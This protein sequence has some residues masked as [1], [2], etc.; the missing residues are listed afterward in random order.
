MNS[1]YSQAASL[2][3]AN[4]PFVWASIISQDGSTPRSAGAQMIIRED[5]I[6]A[7][8]GGG[9]ME[10]GVIKAARESV[11]KDRRPMILDYDLS[12]SE[13]A[14]SDFICGG[15]CRILLAYMEPGF[16]PVFEAAAEAESRGI[17]AWLYYILD[18]RENAIK[19]FSLAINVNS[20]RLVG[21][22]EGAPGLSRD[23][24]L[25]PVRASIHGDSAEG[26][27]CFAD[28]VGS[29]PKLYLLGGGHVSQ[30]V[31]KLAV[32][33][34]FSVTVVDDRAEYASA[35]RFPDCRCIVVEDFARLPDLP[36]DENS[37][38]IIMT[39]GHAYDRDALRWALGKN[40]RY[41]GMI[42]SRSKRDATYKA[43]EKEG[44]PM[45]RMLAVKCP[46][47][48][49][50]NA[51]TPAEIAVSIMAEVIAERRKT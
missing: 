24:L 27:R 31:A 19:P 15:R 3:A 1:L 33:T 45:E 34:G 8:I 23:M 10:G 25:S 48:L 47:G 26:I 42:G 7:T 18:D 11:M 44:F 9:A 29:A 38:V 40:P 43:L 17:P 32:G 36:V 2:C 37:Y 5:A 41:L 49:P 13:A 50:I 6:I 35:A 22:F 39:R 12:P 16:R 4:T 46:I 28:D 30:E 21:D 51:E 14:A 20:E